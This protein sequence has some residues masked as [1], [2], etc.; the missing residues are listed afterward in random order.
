[1]LLEIAIAIFFFA[2]AFQE[3]M[4]AFLFIALFNTLFI[5]KIFEI[6]VQY[7][8]VYAKLPLSFQKFILYRVMSASVIFSAIPFAVLLLS[9]FFFPGNTAEFL[10]WS[11]MTAAVVIIYVLYFS[12]IILYFFPA[13]HRTDIPMVIGCF[14]PFLV[15]AAIPIGLRK[16][17]QGWGVRQHYVR[18]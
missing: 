6:E 14:L 3:A 16:G 11:F 18:N 9:A 1:M 4:K 8:N 5:Q 15:F 10:R 2:C 13:V 7:V 17:K 12:S